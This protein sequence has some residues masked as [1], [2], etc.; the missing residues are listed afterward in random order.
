MTASWRTVSTGLRLVILGAQVVG[1][2]LA[3][4]F[5]LGCGAAA[6]LRG[7]DVQE[8]V[9]WVWPVLVF[10]GL[11]VMVIGRLLCTV[12]RVLCLATP[13][14]ATQA[15]S[16]IRLAVIF[17]VCS[18]LSGVACIVVAL[19]WW[20]IPGELA[21][22]G[23][24]FWVLTAILGRVCFFW[25][26]Q[27]AGECVT[28]RTATEDAR[29]L[30]RVS[31][32]TIL[33]IVVGSLLLGVGNSIRADDPTVQGMCVVVAVVGCGLLCL[34]AM[35]SLFLFASHFILVADLRRV[36]ANYSPPPPPDDPD[37]AYRDRYMAAGGSV[38]DD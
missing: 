18:L 32:F 35:F 17:E 27:A 31:I 4:A 26:A 15:R 13:P 11:G 12:G 38:A 33:S 8:G 14:E 24:A 1:W 3:S 36:L 16:R 2:T 30:V 29:R 6:V 28:A 20:S 5:T 10:T 23:F 7:L 21:V 9:E 37:A 22:I 19:L 34:A 25:F